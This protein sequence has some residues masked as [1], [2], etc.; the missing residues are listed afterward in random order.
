MREAPLVEIASEGLQGPPGPPGA[1]GPQGEP[2][3]P[4]AGAE[5]L[6]AHWNQGIASD[7][8]VWNHNLGYRP[9]VFIVDSAGTPWDAVI[10]HVD[11]NT[12]TVDFKDA[13]TGDLWAS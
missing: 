11:E 3:A 5:N 10:T 2:G 13:M 6:S 4:G 9:N 1:D 8:W 12:L 7:H